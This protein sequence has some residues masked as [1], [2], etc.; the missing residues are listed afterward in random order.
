MVPT[1]QEAVGPDFNSSDIEFG[2]PVH[3]SNNRAG[4]WSIEQIIQR[5]TTDRIAS[6]KTVKQLAFGR[7]APSTLDRQDLWIRRFTEY[8]RHTLSQDPTKPFSGDDLIRFLDSVI[9]KSLSYQPTVLTNANVVSSIGILKPGGQG[10]PAPSKLTIIAGITVI[11]QYGNF[12]WDDAK[13]GYRFSRHDRERLQTWMHDATKDGRLVKGTWNPKTW[14]GFSTLS[15]MVLKFLQHH[16][17]VGIGNWDIVIARCLAATLVSAVAGRSGDVARTGKYKGME[18]LQ[19]RHIKMSLPHGSSPSFAH[20][21]ASIT[22]AS[23]KGY[24]DVRNAETVR[25]IRPLTESLHMCPLSWMIVHALRQGLVYGTT[26]AEVLAH[27]FQR[28]DRTI[29]WRHPD[30]PVLPLFDNRDNLRRCA[31]SRPASTKQVYDTI[32][33]MGLIS[34]ILARVYPHSLR[35]GAARDVAHLPKTTEGNGF[36][37]DE[38]RQILGHSHA[39]KFRGVTDDYVGEN[40]LESYNARA[41]NQAKRHRREPHF[42]DTSAFEYVHRPS[43]LEERNAKCHGRW[44]VLTQNQRDYIRSAIRRDRWKEFIDREG[45]IPGK[46]HPFRSYVL[47]LRH[48]LMG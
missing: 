22:L 36:V 24:K 29:E 9:G 32:Q 17:E 40:S 11:L 30:F 43:S 27:T 13:D 31:L 42:S 45:L 41:E 38:H 7:G 21:E 5:A 47:V 1:T 19:W 16:H 3:K 34:N 4:Q 39:S 28:P 20:I 10:R 6:K 33:Q 15:R 26:L 25:Y 12:T 18:Y 48:M 46:F 37:T 35:L 44:D 14:I 23:V 2:T 8:R